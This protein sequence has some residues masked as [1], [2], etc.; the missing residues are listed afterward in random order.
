MKRFGTSLV[1]AAAICVMV[2]GLSGCKKEGPVER[3]GKTVDKAGENI[4][5]AVQDLKK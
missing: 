2:V 3:A 1:A 5:D 4:K